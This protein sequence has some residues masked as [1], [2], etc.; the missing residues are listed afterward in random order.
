MVN[1]DPLPREPGEI[2]EHDASVV[3]YRLDR[4]D[5]IVS[6]NEGWTRFARENGGDILCPEA[7]IGRPVRDFI[8]GDITRMFVD[9]LI[10]S[11]RLSG[12]ERRIP[13][14]CD[15]PECKRFM[16]MAWFPESGAGLVSRHKL[17][18]TERLV[19]P[20]DFQV[21]RG[22]PNLLVKRCSMCNR[23]SRS[24][25]QP[26]E[27]DVAELSGW[28]DACRTNFVVYHVCRDCQEAV[29]DRRGSAAR[30]AG[31]AT[32]PDSAVR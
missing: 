17:L 7:V 22:A 24:G 10:Q 23:L 5:R 15:T 14:R 26:L 27:P 18:R 1:T 9:T 3:E 11:I 28:I 4:H 31:G 16:E 21:R 25:G 12:R 2:G 29:L 8:C 20:I 30:C 19:R 32:R 13:Y 6:V